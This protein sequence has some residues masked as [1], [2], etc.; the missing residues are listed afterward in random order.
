[1]NLLMRSKNLCLCITS[2][3]LLAG[4]DTALADDWEYSLKAG[5]ANAPRYSGSDQRMTAPLLGAAIVSPW[6]IFLDTDK[7]LGWGYEGNALSFSAYLGASGS[8]KD[9]NEILH[10]GSRRLKGM[11]EI[12]SRAQLGVSASYNLGGVI[13]G[14]TLEHALKEDDHKDSGKAFTHLELSVG[15]NLYDGR[16]G[17]IDASLNS[18]FGDRNYLQTWYGVTTGQAAQSRF[19]AY[20][21]GA[22]NISN[23][24]NLTW[25]VPISEHIQFSTL[26]DV[27]YLANEAGKSPI[28]EQRLQ[29]SVMGM[30]EYTF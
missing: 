29:T 15:T 28:V 23:G 19:K 1:M 4:A 22:G 26:L 11:G 17:S 21:A 6:G 8:R 30:V 20:K 9:K 10:A 13:V 12:K 5:V 18:H 7:G 24:M 16:Y 27:Q 3:C 2:A 14:A 25:S